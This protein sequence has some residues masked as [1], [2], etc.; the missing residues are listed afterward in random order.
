MGMLANRLRKNF[1]HLRKWAR[2]H[3]IECFRVYDHDIPE[4]PLSVDYLAGHACLRAGQSDADNL[5]EAVAEVCEG[6]ELKPEHCYGLELERPGCGV[7]RG[8][9]R[10]LDPRQFHVVDW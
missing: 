3:Q 4:W 8:P 6:L 9:V 5:P 1:R 7:C 10:G 2:R